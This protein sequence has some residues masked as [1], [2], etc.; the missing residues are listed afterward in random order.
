M[1]CSHLTAV[2]A[3]SSVAAGHLI[4]PI[5]LQP[6][7]IGLARRDTPPP[8]AIFF[9]QDFS[10]PTNQ[11]SIL[12]TISNNVL[13]AA[14][15]IAQGKAA[16]L[17][18]AAQDA[19]GLVKK[20]TTPTSISNWDFAG[21]KIRGVNLGGWLVLEVRWTFCETL[22]LNHVR[23][24]IGFWAFDVSGGEP[25]VQGQYAYLLQ[26]IGWCLTHGVKVIVDVHGAPGSQNGFDNSGRRGQILWHTSQT[27]VNRT[28]AVIQTL[29]AELS[30]PQ[31]VGVVTAIQLLN[32]PAGFH[33]PDIVSVYKKFAYDG[34]GIVRTIALSLHDAFQPLQSWKDFMPPSNFQAVS[35]DTHVYLVFS[36]EN[37]KLSEEERIQQ[38]CGMKGY[39]EESNGNLWTIVGEWSPAPTDCA[40]KVNG[41]GAGSRYDGTY[42]GSSAIGSCEGMSGSG[43][44]F[45]QEYKT[46]L[47]K[48]WEVQTT[49]FEAST[50]G[51]IMWAWKTES[52]A[53]WSWQAG[54]Q[55][56]WIP[57]D[58]TERL[59]GDQCNTTATTTS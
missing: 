44:D 17:V 31:Y 18:S 22:G 8:T 37:L 35:L 25:Y 3:F 16:P 13:S 41:Q 53:D 6:H 52:A 47:R 12:Q 24:P 58:P 32:E 59:Y 20:A 10:S 39:L 33:S 29:S 51:Y 43:V 27:N 45:S 49:V 42:P 7:A 1:L 26:A 14:A 23:I 38:I 28:L 57:Q 2:L 50:C 34:Y 21:K 40:A 19:V 11:E 54:V 46:F 9:S 48:F 36:Q 56:G 55:G 4:T 15:A 30:K 5:N